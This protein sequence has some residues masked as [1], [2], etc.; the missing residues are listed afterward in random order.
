MKSGRYIVD[1]K[2]IL[3][4][5]SLDIHK[6]LTIEYDESDAEAMTGIELFEPGCA[7]TTFIPGGCARCR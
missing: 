6:P 4:L 3:G 1:G 2:S 5:L 7:D